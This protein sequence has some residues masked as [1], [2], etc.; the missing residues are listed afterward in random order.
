MA[1]SVEINK[2]SDNL[3]HNVSTNESLKTTQVSKQSFLS[4]KEVGDIYTRP[5]NYNAS[6]SVEVIP[7]SFVYFNEN[8]SSHI[9]YYTL[10]VE[11]TTSGS[12]L[13]YDYDLKKAEGRGDNFNTTDRCNSWNVTG[14]NELDSWRFVIQARNSDN[15]YD[16]SEEELS[17]YKIEVI[18]AN[19]VQNKSYSEYNSSEIEVPEEYQSGGVSLRNDTV[20]KYVEREKKGLLDKLISF[21]LAF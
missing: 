17:D 16:E 9:E 14:L 11:S 3:G 4:D 2:I 8:V 21:I 1:N 6:Q 15:I 13:R 18:L 20:T 7:H 19:I 12:Q 5:D 10:C